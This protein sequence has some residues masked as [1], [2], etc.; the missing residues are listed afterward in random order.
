MHG[1]LRTLVADLKS[2]D[3]PR[4]VDAARAVESFGNDAVPPLI[5]LLGHPNDACQL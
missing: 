5:E 1:K 4:Q 3:I 2:G